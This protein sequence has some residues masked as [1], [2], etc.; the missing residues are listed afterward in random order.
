MNAQMGSIRSVLKRAALY[1]GALLLTAVACA[2]AHAAPKLRV[3]VIAPLTGPLASSGQAFWNAIQLA[4]ELYG[5]DHSIEFLVEDDGFQPKNSVACARKFIDDKV[6]AIMIFGTPTGMAVVPI[7]EQAHMPLAVVTILDKVVAGKNFAVRHFVA[8]QAENERITAEVQRRGYKRIAVV[9]SINDATLSLRD[10][11]LKS[12][13]AEVVLNDEYPRDNL[14]F[15]AT[16]TKIKA[17]A[18]DAVYH[19]LFSPQGPIFTRALRNAGYS[20]PIFGVHNVED[21]ADVAAA[22]GSYDG[23]WYVTGDDR[24]AEALRAAYIKRFGTSPAMGWGNGFDYAKMFIEAAR[25]N[26]P[27]LAYLKN[28]KD[29]EGVF[30][31]YGAAS[32]NTFDLKATIKKVDGAEFK[33]AE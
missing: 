28:L 21:P 20:G 11:F 25:K 6:D 24:G 2:A 18:P 10:G 31:R 17:A 5:K 23:I 32:G 16:A 8:W 22:Q 1:F 9:T 13:V 14:D 7:T 19:L 29:F 27:P 4:D 15:L 30:G 3:G 33:F 12:G 26:V